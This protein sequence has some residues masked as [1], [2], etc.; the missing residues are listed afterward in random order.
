MCLPSHRSKETTIKLSTSHLMVLRTLLLRC[1]QICL[2]ITTSHCLLIS[3]QR[4]RIRTQFK[5]YWMRSLSTVILIRILMTL[6]RGEIG[7]WRR[8]I[9]A[10]K[11]RKRIPKALVQVDLGDLR[12][13][14]IAVILQEVK[15]AWFSTMLLIKKTN[16]I[17][18]PRLLL[19]APMVT[20]VAMAQIQE[21]NAS[22]TS[23]QSSSQKSTSSRSK[24]I[25][26]KC[27]T[28]M[29]VLCVKWTKTTN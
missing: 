16:T 6:D 4:Y 23:S 9:E 15:T 1:N 3:L 13:R 26:K 29:F 8:N 24:K 5:K 14:A 25:W 28:G 18:D 19:M 20:Q 17:V 11:N 22:L 7:G 2:T 12:E 10:K 27:M 21:A